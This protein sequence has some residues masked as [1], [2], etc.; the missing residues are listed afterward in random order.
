[1]STWENYHTGTLYLGY[2][3]GPVEGT[4]AICLVYM[5]TG[6]IGRDA[7]FL[8]MSTIIGDGYGAVGTWPINQVSSVIFFSISVFMMLSSIVNMIGFARSTK[9]GLITSFGRL[10]PIVI[11][12]TTSCIWVTL[13]GAGI[14]ENHMVAFTGIVG[15]EFCMAVVRAASPPFA[16]SQ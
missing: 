5:L 9:D 7:W 15:A 10:A 3:N 14:L 12:I 2:I 6:F 13:S 1:M 11:I 16:L 8:P 4:L